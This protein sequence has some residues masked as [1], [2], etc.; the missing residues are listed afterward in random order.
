MR[1]RRILTAVSLLAVLAGSATGTPAAAATNPVDVPVV[2]VLLNFQ[3]VQ[4]SQTDDYWAQ[5]TF[6]PAVDLAPGQTSVRSYYDEATYGK[7]RIIPAAESAGTPNDGI[8]GLTLPEPHPGGSGI[9]LPADLFAVAHRSVAAADPYINFKDFDTDASGS[10]EFDEL[11]IAFI[12]A[13]YEGSDSRAGRPAIWANA[14]WDMFRDVTLDNV[15]LDGYFAQGEKLTAATGEPQGIGTFAHELGHTL[16]LD[17][18]YDTTG[19]SIGLGSS[20]L[21]ASG[22][23]LLDGYLPAHFDPYSLTRLGVIQPQVVTQSSTVT[24]N[25]SNTPEYNIVKVPITADSSQYFL[26]ENRVTEGFDAGLRDDPTRGGAQSGVAIYHVDE[27]VID[28]WRFAV[29][30]EDRGVNTNHLRKGVDLE[31]S[32]GPALDEAWGANHGGDHYFYEGGQ[33]EF[34]PQSYP[35]S[36]AYFDTNTSGVT[37][38]TGISMQV[39]G[40]SGDA[41]MQ[42]AITFGPAVNPPADFAGGAGTPSSPYLIQTAA[43]LDKVR[44]YPSAHFALTSDITFTPADFVAGGA[45]FN[46]GRGFRVL[47]GGPSAFTGSLD[48]R[49]H[50]IR[51][52]QVRTSSSADTSAGLFGQLSGTVRNLALAD[53]TFLADGTAASAKSYAGSVAGRAVTALI[54][55]V[56]VSGGSV[57]ADWAGGIVGWASATTISKVRN[58]ATVVSAATYDGTG[59]T[60]GLRGGSAGGIAG[61]LQLSQVQEAGNTGVVTASSS[62][63]ALASEPS[64]VESVLAGGIVGMAGNSA[65]L[66]SYNA[67]TVTAVRSTKFPGRCAAYA[68]GIAATGDSRARIRD[69][70]N[71]GQITGSEAASVG[72]VM[73]HTNGAS[74]ARVYH[75]GSVTSSSVWK[76]AVAALV[77]SDVSLASI[78]HAYWYDSLDALNGI[79][80]GAASLPPTV[81]LAQSELGIAASFVGFDFADVWVLPGAAAHPTPFAYP[82]LRAWRH[83]LMTPTKP[84]VSVAT[85]VSSA[86]VSWVTTPASAGTAKSYLVERATSPAGAFL[87]V[88]TTASGSHQDSGL[89]PGTVYR[90]RVTAIED[91]H[92]L[93]ASAPSDPVTALLVPPAPIVTV[94]VSVGAA[95]VSWTTVPAS[96]GAS[97]DYLVERAAALG[98]PYQGLAT[99]TTGSFQDTGLAPGTT[100]YYRVTAVERLPGQS[101]QA[102]SPVV[103]AAIPTPPAPAPEVLPS[104][105]ATTTPATTPPASPP[106]PSAESGLGGPATLTVKK[107]S[108]K[109]LVLKWSSVPGAS[110]YTVLRAT[111]ATGAF[112]AVKT[113]KTLSFTNKG[114]KR[115]RKYFYK[116]KA[117][118]VVGGAKVHSAAD[119]PVA[120]GKA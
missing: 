95:G 41:Q 32:D 72:G 97:K 76:G 79:G 35:N 13:G 74:I 30:G 21:M 26:L 34:G 93:S 113:T 22:V 65:V 7:Y 94:A 31:E 63:D 54:E 81:K 20:S 23:N 108:A 2:V 109:K 29:F 69:S 52:L 6:S 118:A 3:D 47:F 75:A 53:C 24:L 68:A 114:L 19:A 99:V 98:G 106:P 64:N 43:Q 36:E 17:D 38:P 116:V 119:S 57:S 9:A 90:Y 45:F 44:K 73:G 62:L 28:T 46:S 88:A 42:V 51:G 100:Y 71:A 85:G 96:A 18:L 25:G 58:S 115:G 70:Y 4:I 1:L 91:V 120:W 78:E 82:Q 5:H 55:N 103:A 61:E 87:P 59:V 33:T 80:G 83:S 27:W 77:P 40:Q 110:G 56:T 105:P 39:S 60:G 67:G 10:T 50:T 84:S 89:A 101:K 12:F 112:T 111:S 49:G 37:T 107:K 16:G 86:V 15:S 8:V 66:E 117:Y 14:A 48:G 11:R 92:G 104:P 102:T